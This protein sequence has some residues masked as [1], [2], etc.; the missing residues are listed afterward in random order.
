MTRSLRSVFFIPA[1]A[2]ALLLAACGGGSDNNA[3]Q[4]VPSISVPATEAGAPQVTGDMAT[5][6]FNWFNYR[7]QQLGL[8]LLARNTQINAAAQSHSDYQKLNGT[9]THEE[10]PG[11]PGFTGETLLERLN[12]VGYLFPSQNGYAYGEVISSTGNIPGASAAEDLIT[13]IYHRFVIFEPMFKDGGAGAAGNPGSYTYFTV[14]FATNNLDGGLGRGNLVTY[15]FANQ[16]GVPIIFYSDYETP[17]PVQD[18]N[19]VG[20]PISIHTDITSS[21]TVQ[22]FTVT[23]RGGTPLSTRLLSHDT[24]A[25]TPASNAA[26]IPISVLTGATLYDVQFA[27]SVDGIAVSRSWTFQTR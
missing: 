20:Y 25:Q 26:I 21:V 1:L 24:D 17:D 12:A 23:P 27:G 13:A 22:S 3:V 16:T 15:P 19:E 10:I 18:R 11:K 8:Q 2:A 6:G 7:R 4:P 9:I 14:D 5:D